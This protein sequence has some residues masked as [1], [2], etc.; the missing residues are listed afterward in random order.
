[1][2][3]IMLYEVL[4]SILCCLCDTTKQTE[5]IKFKMMKTLKQKG[6]T[7]CTLWPLRHKH[8]HTTN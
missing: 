6:I 2:S 3:F 1:M 5:Q 7:W 4:Y 8:A